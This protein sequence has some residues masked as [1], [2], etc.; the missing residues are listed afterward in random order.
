MRECSLIVLRA[1]DGEPKQLSR[2]RKLVAEVH[3][4]LN[5]DDRTRAVVCNIEHLLPLDLAVRGSREKPRLEMVPEGR[6]RPTSPPTREASRRPSFPS[7][8]TGRREASATGS[9]L[10]TESTW[11]S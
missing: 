11:P 2:A 6:G 1:E 4:R 5:H 3:D 7:T 9:R 10:A 8:V